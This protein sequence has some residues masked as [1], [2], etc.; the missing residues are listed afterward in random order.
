MTILVTRLFSAVLLGQVPNP[1]SKT[2]GL[3]VLRNTAFVF[4]L[5]KILHAHLLYHIKDLV[6]FGAAPAI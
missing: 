1:L 6:G 3:N 2:F 4:D 5:G